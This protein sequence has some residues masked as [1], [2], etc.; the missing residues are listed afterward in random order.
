MLLREGIQDS[1]V[2]FR[3]PLLI[4]GIQTHA[5]EVP[6]QEKGP[7]RA[8][9]VIAAVYD[10]RCIRSAVIDR[11]YRKGCPVSDLPLGAG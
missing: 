9:C 11:R 5:A 1:V 2:R 6:Y 4:E 10:S 8:G 3:P 7:D